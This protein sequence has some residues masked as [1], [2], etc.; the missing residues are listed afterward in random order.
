MSEQ[1][2]LAQAMAA[3]E[4]Q[5]AAL[6]GAVVE[7]GLAPLREKLAALKPEPEAGQQ[8]KQVTLL[9][10]DIAGFTP[11]S[12]RMDPE[13]LAGTMNALWQRIDVA[14]VAHGGATTNT[15]AMA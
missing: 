10:A 13:V 3:L 11:L 4:A 6:G 8:R 14:I 12:E 2:Q 15:W 1:K 5:W 9:F 7:A